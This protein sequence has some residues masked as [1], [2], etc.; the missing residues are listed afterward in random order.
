MSPVSARHGAMII[1]AAML[2]TTVAVAQQDSAPRFDARW[3]AFIGCWA[4]ST[5]EQVG[6]MVCIMPTRDSQTVEFVQVAGDSIVS[7]E[8]LTASG[9]RVTIDRADCTGWMSGIW[10]ADD[11]R[12]FMRSDARCG[13][14]PSVTMSSI[15]SF[16]NYRMFTRVERAATPAG[17][18]VRVT[19]L[20]AVSAVADVPPVVQSVL[21]IDSL[22]A[23]YSARIDASALVSTADVADATQRVEAPLV[24]AW[25]GDR[26]QSFL[27]GARD[28]IAL[29]DAHVPPSVIDVM[30]AVSRP[31]MFTLVPSAESRGPRATRR[32][33]PAD[34]V[35]IA[36]VQAAARTF[37]GLSATSTTE[38]FYPLLRGGYGLDT[39]Y[40]QNGPPGAPW[41]NPFLECYGKLDCRIMPPDWTRTSGESVYLP[42]RTGSSAGSSDVGAGWTPGA[43]GGRSAFP[44]GGIDSPGMTSGGVAASVGSSTSGGASGGAAPSAAPE[45]RT[46]KPRP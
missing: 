15:Y 34:S 39:R 12:L 24:E 38:L 35:E 2:A 9:E 3:R 21:A 30:I 20:T 6:P 36:A 29:Q 32:L 16:D 18:A 10:S 28:L 17:A 33:L 11:R 43:G 27:L 14:G 13:S 23:T 44:S 40:S 19:R 46:A 41:F 8:P 1:A 42:Q 37:G 22:P 45:Q 25:L 7:R 26:K 31:D 4:T 5:G